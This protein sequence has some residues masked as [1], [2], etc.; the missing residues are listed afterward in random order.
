MVVQHGPGV[1]CLI[2]Q[3]FCYYINYETQQKSIMINHFIVSVVT[4][5]Y[6]IF[7]TYCSMANGVSKP[8]IFSGFV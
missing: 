6:Y 4:G 7:L 3:L 8:V 1:P 2:E 5:V